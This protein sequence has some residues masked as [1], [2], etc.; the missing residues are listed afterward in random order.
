MNPAK[1]VATV[2]FTALYTSSIWGTF[3]Y[4]YGTENKPN[5]WVVGLV[6][7]SIALVISTF[8]W[9]MVTWNEDN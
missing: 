6:A 8:V 5:G 2:L 3:I 4:G 7:L 9:M 1:F